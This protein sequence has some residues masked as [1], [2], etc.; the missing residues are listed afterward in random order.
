M[1]SEEFIFTLIIGVVLG[2]AIT[3][4][5]QLYGRRK[6]RQAIGETQAEAERRLA[7][8]TNAS[9]RQIGQIDRLQER[10]GVL[11]QIAVE[12]AHRTAREIER[13]R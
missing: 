10:I 2:A 11:E 8:L 9:D 4:L 12:P 6:V 5:I 13:L 7:L 3:L 1:F